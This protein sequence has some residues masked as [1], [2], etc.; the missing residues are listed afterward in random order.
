[1]VIELSKATGRPIID[2]E[3]V[4]FPH[5]I[6]YAMLYRS[7]IDSF[8]ELSK[9]KRPPRDLWDKPFKLEEYFDDLFT[10]KDTDKGSKHVL[11]DPDEIE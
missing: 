2:A 1:M 8:R 10:S 6:S 11:F 3:V 7:R 9:D 5:T 4:D